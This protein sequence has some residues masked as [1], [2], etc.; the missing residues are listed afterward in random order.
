MCMLDFAARWKKTSQ[1][2]LLSKPSTCTLGQGEQRTEMGRAADL[3][4]ALSK[5]GT[6]KRRVVGFASERNWTV[7]D[8][9]TQ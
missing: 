4:D 3:L 6:Y 1:R 7:E 8:V 9:P 2:G 5:S